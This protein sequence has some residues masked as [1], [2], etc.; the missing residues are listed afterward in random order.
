MTQQLLLAVTLL[1]R[2]VM[3]FCRLIF[4]GVVTHAV[5]HTLKLVKD[6]CG[7]GINLI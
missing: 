2:Q 1:S 3:Q 4:E 5:R 6:F 7:C